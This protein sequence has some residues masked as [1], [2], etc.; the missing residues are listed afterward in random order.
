MKTDHQSARPSYGCETPPTACRHMRRPDAPSIERLLQMRRALHA[1]Y[2]VS[3]QRLDG[4]REA[5]TAGQVEQ[6][7]GE[8]L[9]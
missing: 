2:P 7:L 1:G 9:A 3:F 8:V 4:T 5:L 6:L